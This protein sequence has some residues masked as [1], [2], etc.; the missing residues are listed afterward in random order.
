MYRGKK[1]TLNVVEFPFEI[2]LTKNPWI[3][4]AKY[5]VNQFWMQCSW[6]AFNCFTTETHA[7]SFGMVPLRELHSCCFL[8]QLE[9]AA[10]CKC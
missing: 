4:D 7:A 5:A 10:L 3:F 2:W 1:D 9:A 8:E 6:T